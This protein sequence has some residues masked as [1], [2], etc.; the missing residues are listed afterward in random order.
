MYVKA[1]HGMT[2]GRKGNASQSLGQIMCQEPILGTLMQESHVS[3]PDTFLVWRDRS[4]RG[5]RTGPRHT[6]GP[7]ALDDG[8]IRRA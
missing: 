1:D 5:R 8:V 4:R 7:Q 3:V 6:R 2:P